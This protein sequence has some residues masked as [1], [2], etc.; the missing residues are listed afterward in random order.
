[1]HISYIYMNKNY[2]ESIVQLALSHLAV[3]FAA[4]QKNNLYDS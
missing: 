4:S 2:V 3:D 1:M